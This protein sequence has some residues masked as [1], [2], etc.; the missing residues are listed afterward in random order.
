MTLLVAV[1]TRRMHS[2]ERELSSAD[3]FWTKGVL[4]MRTS[5]LFGAK[6]F[7]FLEIYGMSAR[8]REEELNQCRHFSNKTRGRV[9]FRN[10]VRT[11]FMDGSL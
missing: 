6:T 1:H 7:G 4:Q 10:F 11:S 5:E 8:S 2:R 9:I 3:I